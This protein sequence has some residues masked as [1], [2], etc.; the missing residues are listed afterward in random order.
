V[1]GAFPPTHPKLGFHQTAALFFISPVAHREKKFGASLATLRDP[2][3]KIL[4]SAGQPK[5]FYFQTRVR[6]PL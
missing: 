4:Q 1:T 5:A 6:M 2:G 3:L